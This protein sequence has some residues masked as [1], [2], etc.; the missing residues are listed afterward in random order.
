MGDRK[1][2]QFVL[3]LAIDNS[4]REAR[5]ISGFHTRPLATGE[6]SLSKDLSPDL[7]RRQ[8]FWAAVSFRS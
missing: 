7:F 1:Y 3:V 2:L 6:V 8:S 4:K 5:G